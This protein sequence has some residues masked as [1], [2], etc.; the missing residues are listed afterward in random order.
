MSKEILCKYHRDRLVI[1]PTCDCIQYCFQC[2]ILYRP[3]CTCKK[4]E[5]VVAV[6]PVEEPVV[7]IELEIVEPT[8]INAQIN[9][10]L[11]DAHAA[12]KAILIE[13]IRQSNILLDKLAADYQAKITR[14]RENAFNASIQAEIFKKEAQISKLEKDLKQNQKN[15]RLAALSQ[16][17]S[18]NIAGSRI[19]KKISNSG[20]LTKRAVARLNGRSKTDL[21]AIE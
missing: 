2:H 9:A 8:D 12:E 21:P 11:S 7:A 19:P 13:Q 20:S 15:E 1:P 14:E 6:E 16:G 3:I 18:P 10:A 4:V 17:R 5:P